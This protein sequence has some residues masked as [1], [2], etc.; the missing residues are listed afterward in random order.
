[1]PAAPIPDESVSYRARPFHGKIDRTAMTASFSGLNSGRMEIVESAPEISDPAEERPVPS[2]TTGDTIFD[3]ARGAR[4]GDFFHA[5]LEQLDFAN[6]EFQPL[7]DNQL[8]W[9]GFAGAKCRD[10]LLDTF[11]NLLDVP[12]RPAG[13]SLRETARD[14]RL[15]EL[16]FTF[17]LNRL[18]P[19]TLQDVFARAEV[20]PPE[21]QTGLGRLRFDPVEGFL[22]GFIDLFFEHDGRYYIA[23]WKSNWLGSRS[24]DYGPDQMAVAMLHHNYYLQ[25]DLYALAADLFLRQRIATYNYDRDFG[26]VFYVFLRGVD[27]NDATRGILH[28]RPSNRTMTTLRELAV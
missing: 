6:P 14:K 4:A 3:F 8:K 12:L 5:V 26:G 10:A 20:E 25:A 17:R 19:S 28:R 13:V 1:Q 16:E 18:D 7:V 22:R 21:F 11:G 27:R 2:A 9:H 24:E 15:V 23:D